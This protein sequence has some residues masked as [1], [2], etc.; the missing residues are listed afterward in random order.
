MLLWYLYRH[1]YHITH[2]SSSHRD[3]TLHMWSKNQD[4]VYSLCTIYSCQFSN[5]NQI[6]FNSFLLSLNCFYR[7]LVLPCMLL[8]FFSCILINFFN[9]FV[10]HS[11][12]KNPAPSGRFEERILFVGN[13]IYL[14]DKFTSIVDLQLYK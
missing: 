7:E 2:V 5:Y 13:S 4:T 9:V 3:P 1:R 12:K 11:A 6:S 8:F 14:S 10:Q